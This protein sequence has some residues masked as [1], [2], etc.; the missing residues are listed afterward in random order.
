[1]ILPWSSSRETTQISKSHNWSEHQLEYW[2]PRSVKRKL[3]P[4]CWYN[5]SPG[6]C[7]CKL[8]LSLRYFQFKSYDNPSRNYYHHRWA[9]LV[10]SRKLKSLHRP[11]HTWLVGNPSR[12]QPWRYFKWLPSLVQAI[13]LAVAQVEGLLFPLFPYNYSTCF[14]PGSPLF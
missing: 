3:K 2:L 13:C 4:T 14:D 12:L 6:W 1:M 10:F 11:N 7:I 9:T 8:T 5:S